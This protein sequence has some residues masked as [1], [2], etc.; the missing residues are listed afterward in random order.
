MQNKNVCERC[1]IRCFS[2]WASAP[3]IMHLGY[4][5]NVFA[6]FFSEYRQLIRQLSAILIILMGLISYWNIPAAAAYE[7]TQNE[8]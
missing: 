4:G 5:T 8:S 3:S 7:G 6:E 2:F 1:R